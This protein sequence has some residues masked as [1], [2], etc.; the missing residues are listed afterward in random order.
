MIV[1]AGW[2]GHWANDPTLVI[3]QGAL[4][5]LNWVLRGFQIQESMREKVKFTFTKPR[6]ATLIWQPQK[7]DGAGC[8]GE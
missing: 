5:S 1:G 2:L 3:A 8:G 7:S 4:P 6:P